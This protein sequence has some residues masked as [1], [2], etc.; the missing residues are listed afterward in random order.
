MCASG[1]PTGRII[2]RLQLA[3]VSIEA[4][5]FLDC[6][7]PRPDAQKFSPGRGILRWRLGDITDRLEQE[8]FV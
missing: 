2:R 3:Q 7:L 6:K 5:H 4:I 1:K 8:I